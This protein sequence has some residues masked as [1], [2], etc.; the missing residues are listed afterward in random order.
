MPSS[1]GLDNAMPPITSSPVTL[2]GGC[3]QIAAGQ[4]YALGLGIPWDPQWLVSLMPR[5]DL[6]LSLFSLPSYNLNT[7]RRLISVQC[8]RD[9]RRPPTPNTRKGQMRYVLE[10]GHSTSTFYYAAALWFGHEIV[11]SFPHPP[12]TDTILLYKYHCTIDGCNRKWKN[13]GK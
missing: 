1:I 11:F 2:A 3:T 5:D 8:S 6:S 4:V 7:L 9:G 12:I 13:A 10:I